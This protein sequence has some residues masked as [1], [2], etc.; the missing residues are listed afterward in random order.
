MWVVAV[1]MA[2]LVACELKTGAVT[3]RG[4]GVYRENS[5]VLFYFVVCAQAVAGIICAFNA[6]RS[7]RSR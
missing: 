1:G 3:L 5:P 7:S 4:D 6:L 2:P